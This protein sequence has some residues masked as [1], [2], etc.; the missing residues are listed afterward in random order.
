MEIRKFRKRPD[1]M[2]TKELSIGEENKNPVE[3]EEEQKEQI[4]K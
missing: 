2:E 3:E 1:G 4:S